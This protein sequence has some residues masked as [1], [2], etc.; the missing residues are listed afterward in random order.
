[1]QRNERPSQRYCVRPA[2]A[3]N[4][5]GESPLYMNPVPSS[6]D[7]NESTSRR[8]GRYREGD[9]VRYCLKEAEEQS[10]E[11]VDRK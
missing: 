2:W 5:W 7:G 9:I 1:M 3:V 10:C 11:P 4:L 8:Q 6:A